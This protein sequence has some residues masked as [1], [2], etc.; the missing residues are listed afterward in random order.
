MLKP[1][2]LLRVIATL[3]TTGA[4]SVPLLTDGAQQALLQEAVRY[5][6]H[7]EADVVGRGDRV[8]RQELASFAAFPAESTFVRLRDRLQALLD[9]ALAA[10]RPYPFDGS[11]ELNNL[12]LQK[13]DAGS[14]GITPHRDGKRFINLI[15]VVVLAGRGR[16]FVCADRAGSG[17]REVE[18][19]PGTAIFM[20]AP[21]FRGSQERPFHYVAEIRETRYT[22]GLRQ[23]NPDEA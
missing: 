16:F 19:R 9:E 21:G 22:F 14:L 4:T 8:V 20:R 2:D 1:F 3:E 5:H 18:A 12:V 15:C 23:R 7:R 13:Y 17:A 11:L 6:Y 10:C